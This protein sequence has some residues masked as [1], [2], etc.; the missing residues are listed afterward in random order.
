MSVG[1]VQG[2]RDRGE[3]DLKGEEQEQPAAPAVAAAFGPDEEHRGPHMKTPTMPE[4]RAIS[5]SP[6]ST[7][8]IP[9]AP[10]AARLERLRRP[11]AIIAPQPISPNTPATRAPHFHQPSKVFTGPARPGGACGAGFGTLAASPAPC[12]EVVWWAAASS[13]TASAKMSIVWAPQW[14]W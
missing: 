6:A 9:V 2:G 8:G 14:F 5:V 3:R 7:Q 12:P 10:S 11:I 1:L 4:D 13:W